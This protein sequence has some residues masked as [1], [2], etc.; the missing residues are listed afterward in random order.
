MESIFLDACKSG[1]IQTLR[2]LDYSRFNT[3]AQDEYAFRYACENGHLDIVKF[4]LT[5]E[6]SHGRIDIYA[7]NEYAFRYACKNGHT[8]IV[9]FL[10]ALEETHGQINIYTLS[11]Y[12]FRACI[13]GQLDI[14]RIL[15]TS[16]RVNIHPYDDCGFHK[17]NFHIK[18][19]LIQHE[20]NYDWKFV[21][22]YKSYQKKKGKMISRL[23]LLHQKLIQLRTDILE[24]NVI[25]IIKEYLI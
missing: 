11:E 6:P 8:N 18:H 16:E 20:P 13:N 12:T 9:K 5:L 25:G 3:H 23:V 22:G 2:S 24:L 4:L 19:T 14:V 17:S 10:L 21:V 1:D 7:K 15:L